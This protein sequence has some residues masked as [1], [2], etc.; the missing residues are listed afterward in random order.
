MAISPVETEQR[1]VDSSFLDKTRARLALGQEP[2]AVEILRAMSILYQN[3]P[4]TKVP[5][6]GML[7]LDGKTY[8]LKDHFPFEPLFRIQRPKRLV[9]KCGR[10]VAKSTSISADGVISAACAPVNNPLRILYVT[11]RYEQV[12]RLSVNSVRPFINHSMIKPLLV[13]ESC[14]QQVLQR[15]FL[16]G[17]SLFFSFAFLDCDRIRGLAGIHWINYD[18]V[19]HLDYDFIPIIHQTTAA[20]KMGMSIYSGTPLTLENGLETLWQQSSKAEWVIPCRCCGRWN[21]PSI[22]CEL[23]K[24][25]GLRTI[26][27]A[28]CDKPINPRDKDAHWYHTDKHNPNF[29]GYHVPQ[30][31]MP[32]HYDDPEKWLELL[33]ARDGT[34]PGSSKQKFYNEVLGESAE[35]GIRLV[36]KQDII[37]ASVLGPND[38]KKCID[39]FRRCKVRV[40]AVDWGGGGIDEI[41]YTTAALVGLNASTGKIECHYCLRFHAGHNH[42]QEAKELLNLFREGAC[43]WFAHDFGGAGSVRETLMIQAGLPLKNILGF[44][45]V[46]ASTNRNMVV[47]HPPAIGEIRGYHSLDKSRSLVLQAVCVKGKMISLPEYESS[48]NITH[49]MLALMEDKHEMPGGSDI[50]LIRRQPKMS[51]DFAHS[52]NFGSIAIWHTEQRYPDLSAIQGYKLSQAQLDIAAPQNPTWR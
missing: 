24:M 30:T 50:Y 12:R 48:K 25:I 28:F 20:T 18:E 2:T 7:S 1:S 34:L 22:H 5:L 52:L 45:Y 39:K 3:N 27:C 19:Q 41:S 11:P 47:Y 21:M 13:D 35:M 31:I 15:S 26:V 17:S 32:M 36:T 14:V 42:D 4:T 9:L 10:Q 29:H 6:L 8:S 23:V 16:N 37:D 44:S 43:H 38:F 40:L 46:K 49:D 33:G 51:D